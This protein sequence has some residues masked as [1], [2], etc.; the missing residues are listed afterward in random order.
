MKQCTKCV[1]PETHE[2]IEFDSEGV[3]NICRQAEIKHAEV[4]WK[5]RGEM[6][7][8]IIAEYSGK[9]PY[10]CILPYS[11]GKDSVY[12]LWYVVKQLKLKP[13]VV[14]FDHWGYRPL[15]NKN[16]HNIFKKLGV[17]VL[18][19]TPNWLVVKKIMLKSLQKT[20][21]FCWHCHTGIFGYIM[22]ISVKFNIP[23][24]IFGESPA[25]YRAYIS[26]EQITNLEQGL[27]E[28]MI[29]LGINN[30]KMF[31]MLEGE[32]DRRDL[33][34]YEF[35]SKEQLEKINS[36][37]IWLG[38]YIKWDTKKNVEIIKNELGWQGQ[39]V[40][41]IPPE[42]DYEKIEC[43]WQ[44][45]RD[46]CKFIKRGHGRTNH[47]MCIDIRAGRMDRKKALEL[48]DKYDG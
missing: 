38:N 27:F 48:C 44:G 30:N 22:Q 28:N 34:P 21:D 33:M 32:V 43:K 18:Q 8:K 13:L 46:Y 20:G 47:L 9:G 36:K 29:G 45:V 6:L 11:G 3:C 25:E 35:P 5:S 2:T 12:Q 39:K 4:D 17:D 42:Y 23:L 16:N 31:S 15:V 41:G 40:E 37:A 7:N 14:R 26:F 1:L 19:F 10:D 24:V